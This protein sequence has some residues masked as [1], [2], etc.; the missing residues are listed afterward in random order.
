L[1]KIL[2]IFIA[3]L[4]ISVLF[5]VF[6]PYSEVGGATTRH[7]PSIYPSIQ[8]A[9]D[10]SSTG[11]TVQ[12]AAGT[13]AESLDIDLGIKIVGAGSSQTFVTGGIQLSG[14]SWNG[15]TL[16][17]LYLKGDASGYMN[18]VIDMKPVNTY[19]EDI[20]IKNCVLDGENDASRIAFYGNYVKGDWTW[21]G[22]E[23]KNFK[24][25]YLIDNTQSTANVPYKLDTVR[26]QNN[27]VHNCAGT[28]AIR[29]MIGYETDLV[30]VSGNTFEDYQTGSHAWAAIEVNNVLDLRVYDNT[31]TDVPEN[32]L[33][34][35][36]EAMQI[37]STS[38]WTVDIHDNDIKDN[39][40][41][42]WIVGYL[43]STEVTNQALYVPS[44][45]VYHNNF[46]SN[47][48]FALWIGDSPGSDTSSAIG[49]PLSA[50]NNWWGDA[51]G[52]SGGGP[53]TG[54]SISL[55]IVYCGWLDAA[56]PGGVPA[57]GP[58]INLNT[59][60]NYC[61]IQ[62]A[63]DFANP[64]DSIQ[65][66]AGEF[67]GAI[68]TKPVNIIGEEGATIVDG[69]GYKSGSSFHAG[70]LLD[71]Y[72]S[73][74]SISW[75]TFECDSVESL[76]GLMFPIFS[77]GADD[78]NIHDNIIKNPLQGISN[79]NGNNWN[80]QQNEIIGLQT[81]NGGGIGIFSG[82]ID[83]TTSNN[84]VISNNWIS[85][86]VTPYSNEGG[87]YST[88]AVA[89]FSDRRWPSYGYNG[90]V[91]SNNYIEHNHIDLSG[92]ALG[93]VGSGIFPVGIEVSELGEDA[94]EEVYNN[95][96]KHNQIKNTDY[97]ISL[98]ESYSNEITHN[99][100]KE[101]NMHG[102]LLEDTHDNVIH[103]NLAN[104][105]DGD[106]ISLF[107]S[108]DNT[109]HHN[110]MSVNGENGL[111]IYSGSTGNKFNQNVLMHNVEQDIYSMPAGSS[112]TWSKNVY[113]TS[114]ILI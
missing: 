6:S 79:W 69:P 60:E 104:R 5:F 97:G 76:P 75:L 31:I 17:G 36:G 105:N 111:G 19:V 84:N 10:A 50:V 58:I 13:Y 62:F 88:P 39:F 59:L 29:G 93:S 55:N 35:E 80:I 28:V 56:Y 3:A 92:D 4:M 109:F 74:T 61:T 52:P 11:D 53:G 63:I 98:W 85:G 96:V 7:V 24:N 45:S 37:W 42:I 83:G 101:N 68:V 71:S 70:F 114:N 33:G 34:G 25:W 15:L 18:A 43:D 14:A 12:V 2:A 51:S 30:I 108:I 54:D 1:K 99:Q 44:G 26:F 107:S 112:N 103:H 113:R 90:G 49:G 16:E 95:Y 106:G 82:V 41:G 67:V 78:V 64:G 102:I 8:S 9:I 81:R 91:V 100:V 48:E 65:I 22:N 72:S 40:M 23:I 94:I 89:L 46:E 87:G 21:E 73:G 57:N 77:R 86:D 66:P 20:T 47:S 110:K 32:S 27:H 38:A